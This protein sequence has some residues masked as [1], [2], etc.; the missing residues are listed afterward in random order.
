[1]RTFKISLLVFVL[2]I[3]V[4]AQEGWFWQNPLPQGHLLW[5]IEFINSNEGWA[6]GMYNTILKTTDAGANWTV[7]SNINSGTL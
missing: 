5:D 2:A 3:S 4:S 1:M 6:V 7:Q